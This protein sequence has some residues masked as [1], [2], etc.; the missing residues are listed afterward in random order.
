MFSN[1]TTRFFFHNDLDLFI[2]LCSHGK[3]CDSGG[4]FLKRMGSAS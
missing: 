4:R 1:S 2:F 3:L